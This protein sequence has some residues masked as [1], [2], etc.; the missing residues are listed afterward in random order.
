MNFFTIT[1]IITTV[2]YV[3]LFI[4]LCVL[5]N[6]NTNTETNDYLNLLRTF[7]VFFFVLC[8]LLFYWN[9][10]SSEI[11]PYKESFVF[12]TFLITF[13]TLLL[14]IVGSIVTS[15]LSSSGSTL[16]SLFPTPSRF[17]TI[18]FIMQY[19]GIILLTIVFV[20]PY[21]SAVSL[22]LFYG[23]KKSGQVYQKLFDEQLVLPPQKRR[24]SGRKSG[25]WRLSDYYAQ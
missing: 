25:E 16:H 3:S 20:I 18:L 17:I 24:S 2:L 10:N 19:I 21:L 14:F 9:F 15:K 1:T 12:F 23:E 13:F 4:T 7:E 22:T 11:N 5:K 8:V 6:K